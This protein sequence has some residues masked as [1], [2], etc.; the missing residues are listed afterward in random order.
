MSRPGAHYSGA[1]HSPIGLY[2]NGTYVNGAAGA[3]SIFTH[4]QAQVLQL[5][6]H[7][8]NTPQLALQPPAPRASAP[9]TTVADLTAQERIFGGKAERTW[10]ETTAHESARLEILTMRQLQRA[11]QRKI[12]ES[13]KS[14]PAGLWQAF[15]KLD[16]RSVQ[17]LNLDDLVAGVLHH[18]GDDRGVHPAAHRNEDFFT[19]FILCNHI[20]LKSQLRKTFFARTYSQRSV[21]SK[22]KRLTGKL[23]GS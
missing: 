22:L 8:T 5:P 21:F 20:F 6:S 10:S 4:G 18:A 12:A 3:P 11:L 2:N 16:R 9:R 13:T 23:N 19:I 1:H 15:H 17:H 7:G 14:G